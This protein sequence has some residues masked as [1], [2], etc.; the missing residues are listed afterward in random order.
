MPVRIPLF[1]EFSG[2]KV[3]VL[4]GGYTATKRVEKFLSAGSH[5][6]VIAMDASRELRGLGAQGDVDLII[7]DLRLMDLNFIARGFDL[8]VYAVPDEGLRATARRAAAAGNAL[9]NDATNAEETEV[10]VPFEGEYMGVRL[11]VTTE[12]KSGV[13][14]RAVRDYLVNVLEGSGDMASF[15]TAWYAAKE[16]I[17]KEVASPSRRMQLYMRLRD[18]DAFK[19]LAKSGRVDD[20]LKYVDEAIRNG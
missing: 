14:A 5:V 13:A 12:G 6:I 15:I 4:G 19:S 16:K 9:F 17:K 8:V 11:A 20:V 1:I 3:L 2:K 10:V 18:D 7:G